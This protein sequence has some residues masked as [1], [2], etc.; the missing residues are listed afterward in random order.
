MMN[1]LIAVIIVGIGLAVGFIPPW[2]RIL[3]VLRG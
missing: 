1:Y 3:K 2:D